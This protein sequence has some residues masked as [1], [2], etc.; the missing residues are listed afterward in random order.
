MDGWLGHASSGTNGYY[1]RPSAVPLRP[2]A[3]RSPPAVAPPGFPGQIS[4]MT[5]GHRPQRLAEPFAIIED[6]LLD[7]GLAGFPE[8]VPDNH[9]YIGLDRGIGYLKS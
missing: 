6:A 2:D 4:G 1:P 5:T 8:A 9:E 3:V 7:V